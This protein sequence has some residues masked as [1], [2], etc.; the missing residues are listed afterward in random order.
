MARKLGIV[1]GRARLRY[2]PWV[3]RKT[4]VGRESVTRLRAR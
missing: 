1:G 3:W 4:K 2:E